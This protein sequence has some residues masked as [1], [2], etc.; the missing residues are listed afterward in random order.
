MA[1]AQ[2]GSLGPR[3]AVGG[4]ATFLSEE[5]RGQHGKS[6]STTWVEALVTSLFTVEDGILE[7]RGTGGDDNIIVDFGCRI[8]SRKTT[9]RT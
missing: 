8:S 7:V 3:L 1:A 4:R 9:E 2:A 5:R 6:G